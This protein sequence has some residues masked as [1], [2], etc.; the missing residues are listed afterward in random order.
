MAG[1][2]RWLHTAWLKWIE[3]QPQLAQNLTHHALEINYLLTPAALPTKYENSWE[4]PHW[5]TQFHITE[6]WRKVGQVD[7]LDLQLQLLYASDIARFPHAYLFKQMLDREGNTLTTTSVDQHW[8][9]IWGSLLQ[10]EM[11]NARNTTYLACLNMK[12]LLCQGNLPQQK[13]VVS[14]FLADLMSKNQQEAQALIAISIIYLLDM[15]YLHF[16]LEI[17]DF[18][19]P[20]EIDYGQYVRC[21]QYIKSRLDLR[22][23]REAIRGLNFGIKESL[24]HCIYY[25]PNIR[26]LRSMKY[27]LEMR[28]MCDLYYIRNLLDQDHVVEILC[29]D[30]E[31]MEDPLLLSLLFSI[32]CVLAAYDT[33]PSSI[34]QLI[35]E[36][37]R[38]FGQQAKSPTLECRLLITAILQQV[39][40]PTSPETIPILSSMQEPPDTRA[41]ILYA[42][43]DEVKRQITKLE[44]E[45]ILAGCVNERP[46]S[47]EAERQYKSRHN[48][49][50][51]VA[52][53]LLNQQF[54]LDLDA[55][56]A[57]LKA[58]DHDDARICAAGALMLQRRQ[59]FS[60]NVQIEAVHKIMDV[61]ASE[62]L[63]PRTLETKYGTER[64]D[65]ILFSTLKVLAD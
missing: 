8:Q 14:D 34:K 26:L 29:G 65:E 11:E 48:T 59:A 60:R 12:L 56:Q 28:D 50:R 21:L 45:A 38:K 46:L 43:S 16:T 62:K 4:S 55:Q 44:I 2:A 24:V 37:F 1:P 32:Y 6:N 13:K 10:Q 17:R 52:W 35:K 27:L 33:I 64:L 9:S 31:Q 19:Y 42:L 7:P 53:S 47:Q 23:L 41:T 18:H 22:N 20:Q 3:S 36:S 49:V 58:L 57:M 5:Q 40:E 15:K 61:M 54:N 39:D 63:K 51:D 25:L 30:L